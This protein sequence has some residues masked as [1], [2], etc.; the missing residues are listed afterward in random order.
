MADLDAVLRTIITERLGSDLISAAP[1]D[2]GYSG[3]ALYRARVRR[4]D[5]EQDVVVKFNPPPLH[6]PPS[7]SPDDTTGR[8]YSDRAW[9]IGHVH[10]LLRA[11]G[12]PTY[13]LLAYEPPTGDMPYYWVVMSALEGVS[14]REHLHYGDGPDLE[15]LHRAADDALGAMHAIKRAYDGPV[16]LEAPYQQDWAGAFF[17]ELE[18]LLGQALAVDNPAL[19][20]QEARLRA[21][22][23]T[24]RQGW[25]AAREYVLSHFDGL[26]AMAAHDGRR[27][28]I[29][30]HL[31]LEDFGF[32]DAR[33]PLAGY[34]LGVEDVD[35]RRRVPGAF[36]E[37]YRAHK[38]DDPS[39]EAVRQVFKLFYL[40][41]WCQMGYEPAGRAILDLVTGAW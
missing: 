19:C 16:D 12:L 31:D 5:T 39:F 7:I 23:E 24:H 29:T 36:W 40:L 35:R 10:A 1:L 32:T 28:V 26:Q 22:V 30:G 9:S 21:F 25:V 8:I 13:D 20:G 3:A 4:F 38:A 41:D 17:G 6:G 37:G 11:R 2:G 27:W 14:V 18:R 33:W 34:E 15:G